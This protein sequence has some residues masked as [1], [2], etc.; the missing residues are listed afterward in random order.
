[1]RNEAWKILAVFH[2]RGVDVGDFIH[3]TDFGDAIV[4]DEGRVRD[5]AVREAL[6][7]LIENEYVYELSAGLELTA[8]G[9]SELHSRGSAPAFSARV[10]LLD[11]KIVIKQA[12]L[13]G[14]PPEYE[15]DH[16]RIRQVDVTDEVGIARAVKDAVNG[17][18]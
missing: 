12:A 18:L 6:M 16:E 2:E 15:V 17:H 5:E 1:M 3:F 7:F 9:K 11:G 4:W 14:V 13:R 10:Y 8:K